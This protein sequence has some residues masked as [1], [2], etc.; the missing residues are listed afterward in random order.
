MFANSPFYEGAPFGGKTYRG[1]VWLDVDPRSGLIAPLWKKEHPTYRDY[2]EWALDVPLYFVLRDA[3]FHGAKASR[4]KEVLGYDW[5]YPDADKLVTFIG[6]HDVK[7]AMT[8][9]GRDPAKV[10]L[11]FSLLITLRGVPQIYSGD[12]IGMEGGDDP[13]NRRDFPGGFAGDP[14][15]AITGRTA[16]Q[17]EIFE[18]VQSLLKLRR[19]HP[20]LRQGT[21]THLYADDSVY[22]FA[23]E[24]Q[25]KQKVGFGVGGE[26]PEHLLIVAN[27]SAEAKTVTI[28][29]SDTPL[30]TAQQI[31][32]LGQAIG[33]AKLST[34]KIDVQVPA[35]SLAIFDVQCG[36]DL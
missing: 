3:V 23:R 18:H 5:M 10:K 20:A 29:I 35:R 19:Q 33:S 8:D 17:N 25:P 15:N 31:A 9:A 2:V 1:K 12:E 27:T 28:D 26:R 11:A 4:I 6:N 22:A 36:C 13:D 24:Y 30:F 21:L 34:G 7:R 32:Q 16:P 14:Q